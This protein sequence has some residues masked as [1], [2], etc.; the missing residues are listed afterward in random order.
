MSRFAL[1]LCALFAAAAFAAPAHARAQGNAEAE[2]RAVIDRM[3][4]AMRR[5]DGPALGALFHPTARLQSVGV[6]RQT[7]QPEL[8]TDSIA[9]F[10]RA[11][12]TPHTEVWDE[13]IS[14]VQIRVD[15]NLATAWMN[16]T[17]Y[18]VANGADRL[19]HCGVNAFQLFK[20]GDGWKVIQI[21][22]TRRRENCPSLPATAR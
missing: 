14:D 11:V 7:G 6:S 3:F 1:L 16:Y 19:S 4:D 5:G 2:V 21:T 20:A 10:V 8:R 13:R 12:G 22:D 17:F 9:S 15:G 18:V